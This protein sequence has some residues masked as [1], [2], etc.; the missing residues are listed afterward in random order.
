MK[1][2]MSTEFTGKHK[3]TT[4]ISIGIVSEDGRTFY[5]EFNDYDESQVTDQIKEHI[6]KKLQFEQPKEYAPGMW[7][8]EHYIKSR[9]DEKTPLTQK[10]NIEMRGS[11][12]DIKQELTDWLNQFDEC[13]EIWG[14][15]LTY[16][17]VLFTD[18]FGTAFDIPECVYYIPFNIST[19]LNMKGIDPDINREK[20]AYEF[21]HGE[22]VST[23]D[24]YS[25]LFDAYILRRCYRILENM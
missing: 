11:K 5:A 2:F 12:E 1:V 20:F 9:F 10:F 17:W 6:I 3:N 13:I 8:Q 25:V 21:G 18:I 4:I 24:K 16:D 22:L 23:G 7:E 15:S 19:I 14:D